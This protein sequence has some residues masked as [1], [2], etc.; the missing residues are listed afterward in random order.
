MHH[1][2]DRDR[3]LSIA[4]FLFGLIIVLPLIIFLGSIAYQKYQDYQAAIQEENKQKIYYA[5][6]VEQVSKLANSKEDPKTWLELKEVDPWGTEIKI[7]SIDGAFHKGK[8]VCAG[9][10]CQ[11]ATDDDI[12]EIRTDFS[13]KSVGV[14]IG[15][16]GT[17]LTKGIIKG[18]RDNIFK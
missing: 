10:D 6:A 11:F 1:Y 17:D 14:K 16:T 5:Y 13:A 9:R 8:V 3:T 18:V 2:H 15:R 4:W 12:A 7:E